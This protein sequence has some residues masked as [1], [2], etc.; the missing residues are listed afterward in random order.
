MGSICGALAVLGI[1]VDPPQKPS[2]PAAPVGQISYDRDI[3]PILSENCFKCHGPSAKEAAAGLRLDERASAVKDRGGYA[4]IV[5]GNP[6]ASMIF[7]RIAP[8]DPEMRMPPPTS[9]KGALTKAQIQTLRAWIAQ[10][11]KYEA[12]WSMVPPKMPA[13]P[14]VGDPKWVKNPID[15]FVLQRLDQSGL[16]PEPAA[17]RSTLIRRVSLALTGLSATPSEVGAFLAD[18][19]PDAYDRMVDRYLASPRYGENQARYWLDAVRYGD[20]HGLHL[21]NERAIYPY[22]DWVVRSFNN[23]LPFDKFTVWQL[24]GDLLPKPTTEQLIATGYVRMNPTTNEGGAIEEEFQAKNTFDRVDTT[25]TVFL[26]MTV[27]CARCHDHKY[28]PLTQKEYYQLFAFFNSTA[29][30]AL[31]GNDLVPG[32]VIRARTPE[33]DA[34]VRGWQ[35]EMLALESKVDQRDAEYWLSTAR[36]EPPKASG[37]EVSEAFPSSSFDTAFGQE[38][39]PEPGGLPD[40]ATWKPVA[41][42]VGKPIENLAKRDNAAVFVRANIQSPQERDL[43]LRVGSDDGI[44]VWQNGAL[45]HDNKVLRGLA[46]SADTVKVHLLKGANRFVFKIVNA[47]GPDGFKIDFGDPVAKRIND[48]YTARQQGKP[49]EG[50]LRKL[51]L[52]VGPDSAAASTYRDRQR[53][54]AELEASIP[55]TLIA[56][57]LMQPRQAFIL[58]RGEYNLPTEKVD[59]GLPKALGAL[60]PN[61]PKNRLGLAQWLVSSKNPLTARVIVNRIWQQHFGT[62][63]VKTAEDFGNQGEWPSHPELLDFLAT[64]FVENGWSVK[65]LHHLILTSNAYRQQATASALKRDKD[66]ENRL[67]SRGPRF[68]LDA[69]VLRDQ[70]L[71]VS[72]LL[73]EKLGG[74]GVKPY[75]PSGIWEALAFADSNTAKY[76]QDKGENLYRRSLYL[77]WKRTSP[78]PTML[79][80]DAPMREACVV[81]RSRTNTPLQALV[82]L[83]EPAFVEASRV[84]ADRLLKAKPDDAKRLDLGFRLALGRS[85]KPKESQLLMSSLARYRQRFAQDASAAEG[86]LAVGEYPGDKTLPKAERAA[87]ALICNTLLNT[88]E[89]LT[90]H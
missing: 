68:R 51:F 21:D 66:P 62:G 89:F 13:I 12:H 22:R 73:V 39:G 60:A 46:D 37:W 75:Q 41:I 16:K 11:A 52:E 36:V 20:T 83:N 32:P 10:G 34:A 61:A 19:K 3:R 76:V 7:D 65:K 8:S 58:R 69:E 30:K 25:S 81:R 48:V 77:F 23:D 63:L 24:A 43:E 26:G 50:E 18:A 49:I 71:A 54:I 67:I 9:G 70:A 53:K 40:K 64:W 1:A 57:E 59:R 85:P 5:S 84:F 55:M 79:A 47:S 35:A 28:D 78:P 56:Q 87:W 80:F 45:V 90:Q 2:T 42:E 88:D 15:A 14:K 6:K 86:L 38:F 44:R 4:V 29:D 27:G 72:G 17:D 74:H 82:T 33:Q 31:D